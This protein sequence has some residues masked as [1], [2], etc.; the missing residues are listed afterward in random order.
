MPFRRVFLSLGSIGVILAFLTVLP[1]CESRTEKA[2]KKA[3]APAEAKALPAPASSA[4]RV[5]NDEGVSHYEQGHWDVAEEHFRKA[6][7]ADANLAEAHYN[8]GLALDK[9]GKH[10]EATEQFKKA[11]ELAPGNPAIVESPILKQHI[12][13]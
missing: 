1:A 4:G 7:Q 5:E 8:L 2:Q 9:L 13:T 6:M 12:G 11:K 10:P 3:T